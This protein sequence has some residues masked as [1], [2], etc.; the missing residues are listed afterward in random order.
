M[1]ILL[2]HKLLKYYNFQTSLN[3]GKLCKNYDEN[4]PCQL[5]K[6]SVF[7]QSENDY[8]TIICQEIKTSTP[9]MVSIQLFYWWLSVADPRF[10]VGG[11]DSLQGAWTFDASAFHQK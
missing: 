1:L 6:P 5:E 7:R 10:P 8:L 11:V 4:C 2:Y 9:R 3:I